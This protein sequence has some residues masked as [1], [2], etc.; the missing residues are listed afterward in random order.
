M[1]RILHEI[2]KSRN[3][4][5]LFGGSHDC[6]FRPIH[7][8][9]FYPYWCSCCPLD[10]A[11]QDSGFTHVPG[12]YGGSPLGC[13]SGDYYCIFGEGW[14]YPPMRWEPCMDNHPSGGCSHL[15][16]SLV[17]LS[18]T[19]PAAAYHHLCAVW[20]NPSSLRGR[21]AH[22][23]NDVVCVRL[24]GLRFKK[25]RIVLRRYPFPLLFENLEFQRALF[26]SF[27]KS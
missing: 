15:G 3:L 5:M 27:P 13:S 10:V 12:F 22:R 19:R 2:P 23:V 4:Q 21:N 16:G 18:A 20:C 6:I 24:I 1:W 11:P 17:P 25:R 14:N 9:F 7:W 8:M 26:I